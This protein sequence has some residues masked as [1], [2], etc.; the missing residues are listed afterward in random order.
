MLARLTAVFTDM[1]QVMHAQFF[2]T[3][4]SWARGRR[5]RN[6]AFTGAWRPKRN[7]Q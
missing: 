6:S 2:T 3:F 5:A 7:E 1:L 4:G